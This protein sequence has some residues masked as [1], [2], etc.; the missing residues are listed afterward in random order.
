MTILVTGAGIVG[1]QIARQLVERG[2]RPLLYDLRPRLEQIESLVPTGSFDLVQG[3]VRDATALAD[4]V[5]SHRVEAIVHTAALLAA[6]SRE[7]PQLAM[8]VNIGGT[9]NMLE[10]ARRGAVRRVVLCSSTTMTYPAFDSYPDTLIPED[11]ALKTVSQAPATFYSATKLSSEFFAGLYRKEFGVGLVVV[12]YAAVLG[13]WRGENVGLV[14]RMLSELIE[15]GK[16]GRDA[17]IR[18][19]LFVWEGVEEFIDARDAA[20]GTLAALDHG[21]GSQHVYTLSNDRGWTLDAFTEVVREVY[22]GLRVR[23][24]I[25]AK[26]GFAGFPLV[27]RTTSDIGAA[28]RDLNWRPQFSLR[29]SIEYFS[30]LTAA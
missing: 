8:E 3:D 5:A 20:S 23:Y 9:L 16:Q 10:L 17:V 7:Q 26:G 4:A 29:E 6:P 21:A 24:E 15:A 30:R 18:D 14:A 11:F 12:R 22:P 19:P 13:A 28:A 1:C 27:R 2:V 25:Q